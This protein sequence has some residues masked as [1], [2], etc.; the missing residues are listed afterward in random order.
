M[1]TGVQFLRIV[2]SFYFVVSMKLVTDGVL[3]GS[4]AMVWFMI[5]TFSDL[6]LRVVLGYALAV[7]FGTTGIWTSWTIGWTVGTVMSLVFYAKGVW[8]IKSL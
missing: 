1:N 7:P 4:G 2:A 8:K 5:S 3:R 6:I